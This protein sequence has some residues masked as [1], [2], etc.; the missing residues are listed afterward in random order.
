MCNIFCNINIKA[1]GDF[2]KK[3]KIGKK[4]TDCKGTSFCFKYSK[5]Q[6]MKYAI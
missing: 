1:S 4:R 6:K 3:G 2:K 5:L